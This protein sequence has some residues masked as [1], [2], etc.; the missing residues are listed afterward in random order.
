VV[1]GSFTLFF[2]LRFGVALV[3]SLIELVIGILQLV[4]ILGSALIFH[5]KMSYSRWRTTRVLNSYINYLAHKQREYSSALA[6]LKG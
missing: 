6:S 1:I 2:L 3:T 5:C 4:R